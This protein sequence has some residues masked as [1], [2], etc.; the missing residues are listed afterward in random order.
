M[1][2]CPKQSTESENTCTF[3]LA[4]LLTGWSQWDSPNIFSYEY[5]TLLVLS[6]H[7]VCPC[8]QSHHNTDEGLQD[9]LN[10]QE[11]KLHRCLDG[12]HHLQSEARVEGRGSEPFPHCLYAAYVTFFFPRF[13]TWHTPNRNLSRFDSC[14]S[15]ERN[16]ITTRNSYWQ[17]RMKIL[18]AFRRMGLASK[19]LWALWAFDM[20]RSGTEDTA[21]QTVDIFCLC[22]MSNHSIQD[23]H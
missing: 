1:A 14:C 23:F 15:V 7:E 12:D 3:L 21:E 2:P 13:V 4:A 16:G 19:S 9:V 5:V 18:Q 11:V 10:V 8:G 20:A 6:L 22:A 17:F